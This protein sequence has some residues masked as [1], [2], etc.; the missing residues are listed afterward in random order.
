MIS[1]TLFSVAL[2]GCRKPP[3]LTGC[4]RLELHCPFGA[5]HQFFL[6][7]SSEAEGIFSREE[8]EFIGSFDTWVVKDQDI[9][10]AFARDVSRGSYRGRQRGSTSPGLKII[11]YRNGERLT[12]FEDKYGRILTEDGRIFKY[13]LKVPDLSLLEPP[14]LLCFQLR[15]VCARHIGQLNIGDPF[16]LG[17]PFL[18]REVSSYPDPNQW[19][20]AIVKALQNRY[21][22]YPYWWGKRSK[23]TYSDTDI[24]DR[25]TCPSVRQPAEAE[26][27]GTCPSEPNLPKLIKPLWESHYAMNPNCELNSP[28]D[29]VLLFETKAGWNQHGGPELFTFDNH[30]PRGGCVF[31]NDGTIK[32]I[33][34]KEELHQLR[35]K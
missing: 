3:D 9:I 21:F 26:D 20:D 17:D 10:K 29:M 25:F 4:T 5:L 30:D 32:F 33:R 35:W 15:G 28:P 22:S 7:D 23:R 19:C 1:L 6:M 11:C 13:P 31:L 16:L 24:A 8:M 34:T 27:T 12:S 2:I 18:R 14:E